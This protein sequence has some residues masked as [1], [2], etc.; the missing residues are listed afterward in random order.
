[1]PSPTPSPCWGLTRKKRSHSRERA[2]VGMP[3]PLSLM[4]TL[5]LLP[6]AV[7]TTAISPPAGV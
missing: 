7:I 1:M 4:S 2:A 3:G 5:T 6:S